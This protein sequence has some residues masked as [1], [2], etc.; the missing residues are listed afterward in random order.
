MNMQRWLLSI[1]MFAV[2]VGVG[3]GSGGIKSN[4]SSAQTAEAVAA[5]T[6]AF[7]SVRDRYEYFP[8]PPTAE[9]QQRPGSAGGA[10]NNNNHHYRE[11]TTTTDSESPTTPT[12]RLQ[13]FLTKQFGDRLGDHHHGGLEPLRPHL[14]SPS[15]LV[16]VRAIVSRWDGT[17]TSRACWCVVCECMHACACACECEYVPYFW[18]L[19]RSPRLLLCK[20]LQRQGEASKLL[21]H[22][23]TQQFCCAT[24]SRLMC[25]PKP[26]HATTNARTVGA[27]RCR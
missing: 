27:A 11:A 20:R 14:N 4:A 9:S 15:H 1:L 25:L 23:K 3:L 19:L 18:L 10:H 6:T 2:V 8:Y 16:E 12:E 5:T 22:K 21:T 24:H 26:T 13:Y 7:S 17:G